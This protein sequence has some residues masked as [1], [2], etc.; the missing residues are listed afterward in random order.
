MFYVGCYYHPIPSFYEKKM[1]AKDKLIWRHRVI[2]AYHGAVAVILSLYW[3]AT[4]YTTENSRKITPFELVML[5]HT[6]GYLTMDTVFMWTE[7]FLDMGNF[8]HHFIGVLVYYSI[9]YLQYDYTFMAIHLL[10]GEFSN[11]AMH[12]R[13]ILKRMGL[14]YTKAY[15]LNDFCYYFE[16]L[17]CRTVWIPSIYYLIFN[18]PTTGPLQLCIYPFHVVMSWYYCSFIP[19]LIFQRFQEYQKI[20]KEKIPMGWTQPADQDKLSKVGIKPFELYHT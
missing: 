15:Y 5:S 8:I 1:S 13:E 10:P 7:G 4:M 14:R 3:Y 17:G 2:N 12:M 18:C 6:G 20:Q 11:V 9:A 16:Y 19:K